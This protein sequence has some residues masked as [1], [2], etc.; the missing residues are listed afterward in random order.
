MRVLVLGGTTEARQLAG[1]LAGDA[2]FQATLS[3][4]GRTRDPAPQALPTRVGGFGGAQGLADYLRAESV[5]AVID[6]THPFADQISANAEAACAAAGVPLA[7]LTRRPWTAREGDDWRLVR[8]TDAAAEVLTDLP[9]TVFLTVGRQ[10]LGPFL[11]LDR[12]FLVRAVDPPDVLPAGAVLVLDRGPYTLDS[13]IALMRAHGVGT[14]VTKNS[15]GDAT[16]AKL[17]A[18]RALGLPVVMVDRPP[19]GT[20]SRLYAA[21]DAMAWLAAHLSPTAV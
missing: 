16:A 18:A 5:Q 17:D 8:T 9:D 3:L 12:R 6:A 1:L 19:A 15:G 11:D 4:A 20:A 14:L 13:E 2:R 7:V 21:S 10:E